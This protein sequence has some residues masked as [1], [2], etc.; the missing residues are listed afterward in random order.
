ML[1]AGVRWRLMD[2]NPAVDA[3]PHPECDPAPVRVYT[4]AEL[5]AVADELDPCYSALP[6]FGAA[7]GLRPEEWGALERRHVD[8][9][10]RLV[11][12]EQ[13][14]VDGRIVPGGKTRTSVREVPLSRVALA[15]LDAIPP[16]L[17]TLLVFPD[18]AAGRSTST[19]S[20]GAN[21]RRPSRP[22]ESRL[23]RRRTTCATR[24]RRTR[25]TPA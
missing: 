13:K 10:R 4:A 12:V 25:C 23:P 2:T 6:A 1:A 16:R 21:G 8:R 3:G 15:A 19:T 24:S 5:A 17:D 7:T 14:N 9:T 18:P 22:R 11:R 20:A